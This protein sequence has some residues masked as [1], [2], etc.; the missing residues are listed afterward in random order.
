M[1]NSKLLILTFVVT[2][3]WDLILQFLSKSYKDLPKVL[4]F[5]FIKY[6]KEY[7]DNHTIL[8]AASIAGVTGVLA[9]VIIIS[10]L[11][12]P[13]RGASNEV[14]IFLLL[15]FLISGL[16]GFVMKWSQMYPYLVG[17]YYKK[18]GSFP[19]FY[20]DG[21]SGLIVQISLLVLY[22]IKESL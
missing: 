1:N 10:I 8:G 5:N 4:R 6:L 7:F 17:T 2:A 20:H 16:F 21:I 11:R 14:L 15:S 19:A 3:F 12:F 13:Q 9:Q 18:L 22:R